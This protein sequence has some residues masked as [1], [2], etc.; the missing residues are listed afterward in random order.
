MNGRRCQKFLMATK[1]VFAR[2]RQWSLMTRFTSSAWQ[3]T[4]P[5][6]RRM[7][8]KGIQPSP[9][10]SPGKLL[11]WVKNINKFLQSCGKGFYPVM[12]EVDINCSLLGCVGDGVHFRGSCIHDFLMGG[13]IF[14]KKNAWKWKQLDWGAYPQCPLGYANV[15]KQ[16]VA[17]KVDTHLWGC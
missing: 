4:P 6:G 7:C 13:G 5:C 12:V 15:L 9:L 2:S 14:P 3:V 16:R 11:N 17:F 10:P 8:K 1:C